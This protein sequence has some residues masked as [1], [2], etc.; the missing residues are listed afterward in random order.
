MKK[1]SLGM[2]LVLMVVPLGIISL[3]GLIVLAV[4]MHNVVATSESVYYDQ[5]YTVSS[6]ALNAD[7]DFYQ[8]YTAELCMLAYAGYVDDATMQG[9][10]DDY[11]ENAVQA[12]DR[13]MKIEGILEN[14]PEL[15]NY[16][17]NG[18]SLAKAVDNYKEQSKLWDDAYDPH[19]GTGDIAAQVGYFSTA[20]SE[21]SDM[22]DIV[23]EYAQIQKKKLEAQQTATLFTVM[24]V[25]TVLFLLC[26]FLSAYIIHYIRVNVTKVTASIDAIA[27]KDL[28]ADVVNLDTADEVGQLSRAAAALKKN[29][30]EMVQAL[31]TASG[32]LDG[33]S[34]LM[35]ENTREASQNMTNIDNAAGELANTATATAT[36]IERLSGEMV[37]IGNMT[38]QS[39]T[40]TKSLAS[41]CGDIEEITD[42]G[43]KIVDDLTAATDKNTKAFE[44]IF[45]AINGIDERT[46]KI[47]DASSL[48]TDI[49]SQTNLLSLNASIEAARAGEAGRGFA[50]V[51][52]EIRQL[53]EQSASSAQ[54]INQMI[55]ELLAS[56]ADATEQSK[57]VRQYVDEQKDSVNKT[58]ES[59]TAIVENIQTVNDGVKDLQEVNEKLG[60]GVSNIGNLVDS[61]SAASEENAA[62]AEELSATTST[63]AQA[64]RELEDVGED[65]HTSSGELAHIVGSF[66]V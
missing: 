30:L 28:T 7:R 1:L 57:L 6:E 5:L 64:V 3:I 21:L 41:A 44:N 31:Q 36:D 65:I 56:A 14:Y 22:S 37:D 15:A 62:T 27:K 20:R 24:G 11:D 49:A 66:V 60:Y 33:H 48:I 54:T 19:T 23:E 58:K 2:K 13:V 46:K 34:N 55:E 63:V 8:A 17:W 52:D 29:Q 10:L 18:T 26:A 50:V 9:Y 45:A 38:E 12:L 53:A 40:S 35:A 42:Q 4:S 51:A 16:S 25:V 32:T 59:F 39:V 43:M 61:L 47:G